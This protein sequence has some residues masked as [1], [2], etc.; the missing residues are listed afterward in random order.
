MLKN[1]Y[2]SFHKIIKQHNSV[3]NIDNTQLNQSIKYQ[4][5]DR[6]MWP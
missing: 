1:I 3:F 4:N 5:D 6:I 2:Q